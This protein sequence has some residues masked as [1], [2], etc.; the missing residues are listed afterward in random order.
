MSSA[1]RTPA[2]SPND[3]AEKF[4]ADDQVKYM[5]LVVY[6]REAAEMTRT[7]AWSGTGV[8]RE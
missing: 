7:P 4:V 3:R 2:P 8:A 1:E 5:D 6:A